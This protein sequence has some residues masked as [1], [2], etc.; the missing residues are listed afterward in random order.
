MTLRFKLVLLVREVLLP[1]IQ[2]QGMVVIP[3]LR[4][5]QEPYSQWVKEVKQ[6][7]QGQ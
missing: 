4:V 7:L 6:V 1:L 3:G 5:D 2:R